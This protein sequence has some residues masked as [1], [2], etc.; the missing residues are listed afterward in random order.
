VQSGALFRALP[1]KKKNL[2]SFFD[3]RFFKQIQN[4]LFSLT[5]DI[6]DTPSTFKSTT[7]GIC[8]FA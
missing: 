4:Q 2:S 7:N 5:K 8:P 3:E 1:G 6:Y